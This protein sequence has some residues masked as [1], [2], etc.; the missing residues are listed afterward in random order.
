MTPCKQ[1]CLAAGE[2]QGNI[3][4]MQ[5]VMCKLSDPISTCFLLKKVFLALRQ[6]D[7]TS[8]YRKSEAKVC[9]GL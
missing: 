3:A 8:L 9:P 6:K 4:Y 5:T 2:T 1:Y 7:E